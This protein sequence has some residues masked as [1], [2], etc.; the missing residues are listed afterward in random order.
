MKKKISLI[1]TLL[2]LLLPACLC[3]SPMALFQTPEPT[4]VTVTIPP[5]PTIPLPPTQVIPGSGAAGLGDPYYPLLGNGGY[6]VL[7]YTI[8]LDLN[9]TTGSVNGST[10]LEVWASQELTAFNL[11][12]SGLNVRQVTVD[13][14]IVEFS[15]SGTELTI[16][17]SEALAPETTFVVVVE[18]D[19]IPKGVS[20]PALTLEDGIGWMELSSGIYTINEPSG[21]M[22]WFPSNN[23][24]TDK[25]TYE[26]RI[27][28]AEPYVIAANGL[29][30][31]TIDNGVTRTFV[32]RE[33]HPM[34][35]YLASINIGK[36]DMRES[37]GPDGLPIRSFYASGVSEADIALFDSLP[38]MIAFYSDLIAPYPFEAYGV[39]VMPEQVGVAM[40]NQTLSIFGGDM[41]FEEA[42]AHELA[43]QWFGDSV[44]IS[45]W[46]DIWLN[47][48][49]ATYLEALWIEHA[50]GQADFE[51]YID[52]MYE[53]AL[54]MQAPGNPSISALF[55]GSVY[56]RGAWV[57]HALRLTVGDEAFFNILLT[58]YNRY[59]YSNASSEDFIAVAEEVSG[60][61]LT[62]FFDDWLYGY[63]VPPKP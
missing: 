41:A 35:T 23:Y 55:G 42:I 2:A 61:D 6:D 53:D 49:F 16:F 58:Y 9:M 32:W 4:R 63:P 29:L 51:G 3:S 15:R 38:E 8:T 25:A 22:G 20:D 21:S 50:H 12:M 45:N 7:H 17:P 57:L 10:E 24:P 31:E 36:F 54:G 59:Q 5:E 27:T 19:G 48:G 47:E 1:F 40:E 52:Y 37:T 18:Y 28:V 43:H 30:V 11:D 44:T 56:E 62:A 26:F 33:D 46:P 13:T 60:R 39:V 14:K 34:S